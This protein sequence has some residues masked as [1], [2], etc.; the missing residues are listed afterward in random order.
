MNE[1]SDRNNEIRR[2]ITYDD[3]RPSCL[4]FLPLFWQAIVTEKR[5]S[6]DAKS[7]TG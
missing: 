4:E 1:E 5:I 2:K 3:G 7:I 6:K